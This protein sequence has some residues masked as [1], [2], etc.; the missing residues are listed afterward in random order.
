MAKKKETKAISTAVSPLIWE[1]I[2]KELWVQAK[3]SKFV[4]YLC[5]GIWLPSKVTNLK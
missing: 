4:A 5:T 3:L 1:G 2:L